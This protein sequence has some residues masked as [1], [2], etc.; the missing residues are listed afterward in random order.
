MHG[1]Q[2]TCLFTGR[3]ISY[4]IYGEIEILSQRCHWNLSLKDTVWVSK[5]VRFQFFHIAMDGN[6]DNS[7][8]ESIY[9]LFITFFEENGTSKTGPW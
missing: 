8:F 6:V 7:C 2:W 4:S 5:S 9:T 3:K 1:H